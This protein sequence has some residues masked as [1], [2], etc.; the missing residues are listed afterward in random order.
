MGSEPGDGHKKPC[1]LGE[2]TGSK[3]PDTAGSAT[4]YCF[5][6]RLS[7]PGGLPTRIVWLSSE[8]DGVSTQAEGDVSALSIAAAGPGGGTH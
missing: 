6:V 1:S 7:P 8:A 2:G 4:S 5:E 3:Q